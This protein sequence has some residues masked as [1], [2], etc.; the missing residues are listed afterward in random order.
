[1]QYK[2]GTVAPENGKCLSLHN[3]DFIAVICS[4]MKTQIHS[5]VNGHAEYRGMHICSFEI[6]MKNSLVGLATV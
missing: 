2:Y 5:T 6:S 4:A 3:C 1:M